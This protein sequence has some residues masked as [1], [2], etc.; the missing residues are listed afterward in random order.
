[1]SAFLQE[2]TAAQEAAG[3][4]SLGWGDGACRIAS[5][6]GVFVQIDDWGLANTAIEILASKVVARELGQ[7]VGLLVQGLPQGVCH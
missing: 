1:M 6:G 5:P 3:I 2:V 7:P 4:H